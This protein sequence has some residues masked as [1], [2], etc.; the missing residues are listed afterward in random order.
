LN[1]YEAAEVDQLRREI[2]EAAMERDAV[3]RLIREAI[4]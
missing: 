3:A 1:A 4:R 2:A